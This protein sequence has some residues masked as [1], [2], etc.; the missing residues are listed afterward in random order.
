MK[1]LVIYSLFFGCVFNATAFSAVTPDA[2]QLLEQ[3][4]FQMDRRQAR[5]LPKEE[6]PVT[7][8]ESVPVAKDEKTILVKKF[9]FSGFDGL[10]NAVE[11]HAV[12][13]D[14]EGR[15][16]SVPELQHVAEAVTALL[17]QKGFF[18]ARA[19]LPKQDVTEG[20]ITI[21]AVQARSDGAVSINCSNGTRINESLLTHIASKAVQSGQLLNE[22]DL[23]RAILLMND[24]PGVLA[25]ATLSPGSEP[26]T[27]RVTVNVSEKP[28]LSGGLWIDNHGN[29]Y[30]GAWRGNG[31]VS[32][33]DPF[34]I[35][36]QFGAMFSVSSGLRQGRL[37]YTAPVGSSGLMA[38][39]AFTSMQY[40]LGKDL[41]AMDGKGTA[42]TVDGGVSYPI[43]RSRNFNLSAFLDGE[44]KMLRDD[45]YGSNIRDKKLTNAT[46]GVNGNLTD[47]WFGGGYTTWSASLTMGNLDLSGNPDDWN[48][49]QGRYVYNTNGDYYS[50]AAAKT[51]GNY[52]RVNV[53]ISRLQRL[54]TKTTLFA[55]YYGQMASKN[56]DSSEKFSLGGPYGVR[57]YPVGE[58]S[59]DNTHLFSIELRE[60]LPWKSRFGVLQA[61]GFFDAGNVTLYKDQWSGAVTTQTGDNNYWLTGAGV[62][63]SL[64]K[65]GSYSVL[66][67]Y[68]H[69]IG[70]NPGR[71]VEKYNDS[72]SFVSGGDDADGCDS[73]G[74]FWVMGQL[75]F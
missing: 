2:G 55:S 42:N 46:L 21:A 39:I 23:E 29:R 25:R 47:H 65:Q 35:G 14:S 40:E 64:S 45:A 19:Y 56:L 7:N 15:R 30:T 31:Y 32:V 3:Q 71:T 44:Y 73:D 8:E 33:N 12:V 13:A 20:I 68:A 22:A 67:C 10:A 51:D 61:Y 28:L 38:N 11:L 57:A 36:D 50:Y 18:L 52:G 49:D 5:N 53:S 41:D 1:K 63:L 48:A 59:G 70:D 27:T 58:A 69:K 16:L 34:H 4:Q 6:N 60:E 66:L 17:H 24:I 75:M 9:Q 37:S 26:G 54:A 74:R 62:G 72:G 43:F